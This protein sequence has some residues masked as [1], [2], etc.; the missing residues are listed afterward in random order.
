MKLHKLL[1]R[2]TPLV[3][4]MLS[5]VVFATIGCGG[6]TGATAP[7]G[8]ESS[9]SESPAFQTASKGDKKGGGDKGGKGDK[10]GAATGVAEST[11]QSSPKFLT[12]GGTD[13]NGT[14]ESNKEWYSLA[15]ADV[16]PE[17][18]NKTVG[19]GR[20]EL[21]FPQGAL[22]KTT[23]I[24]ISEWDSHILE[25]E[26]GPHGTKFNKPVTLTIDY[27]G[28]NADPATEYYDGSKLVVVWFNEKTGTWEQ[29]PGFDN[30]E[31]MEYT[32]TLWHFSR[33]GCADGTSDWDGTAGWD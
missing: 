17:D 15:H 10:A 30:P 21:L 6:D 13:P 28:T 3:G 14:Q 18:Q 20:Y 12:W 29:L 2:T 1:T 8:L 24:T 16:R 22:D 25:F 26:L 9:S 31:Q 11:G 23:E 7:I 5:F 4:L 19:G 32:V 33:Y 27:A